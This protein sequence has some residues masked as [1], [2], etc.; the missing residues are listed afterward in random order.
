VQHHG[1]QLEVRSV[2]APARDHG[3]TF[4]IRLPALP[5]RE[6]E[7]DKTD[8]PVV[9]DGKGDTKN[10]RAPADKGDKK[11]KK[12]KDKDSKKKDGEKPA[13]TTSR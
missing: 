13:S 12:K 3:A 2:E 10:E 1:G 4:I 7:K 5:R 8:K 6:K 9:V 11:D